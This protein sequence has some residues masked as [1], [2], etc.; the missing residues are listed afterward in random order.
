V[1]ERLINEFIADAAGQ[2]AG[3]R[4]Q[5]LVALVAERCATILEIEVDADPADG[6]RSA[7]NTIRAA[8]IDVPKKLTP[9][10]RAA[11]S[12]ALTLAERRRDH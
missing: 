4:M 11:A 10:A 12:H 3:Q 5:R 9:G 8:F 2:P 1:N 7:A 6:A